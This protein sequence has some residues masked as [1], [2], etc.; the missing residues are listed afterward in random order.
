MK[1]IKKILKGLLI[2]GIAGYISICGL[3]YFYQE[4]LLFF[5][6]K[7]EQDHQFVFENEFEE[8]DIIT[9][10][11]NSINTLLF[12]RENSKGVIFYLHGNAGSLGSLG[13][14]SE[15]FLPL[16]YDVFIIDYPGY[17]KSSN[18]ITS[19]EELFED[20]QYV[21]DDLKK[22]YSEDKIVVVGY[23][24]GT[25]IAAHLA[26]NNNPSKLVLQAPYYSMI[27]LSQRNYPMIPTFILRYDLATNEYLKECDMPVYL[28]HGVDDQTIPVESSEMLSKEL[29]L[30]LYKLENQGH[31]GIG[32]NK[33]ALKQLHKI[34]N[35][36]RTY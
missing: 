22:R 16:G 20:T 23:S 33:E 24:I 8:R 31:N 32:S 6:E 13:N 4:S 11:G 10:S 3:L 2:L 1:W 9:H 34:L 26:S 19:Q 14:V 25:G 7:L 28:F 18:A 15:Y 36:V 30:P 35:D 29:H 21:Y 27:N 5:P 17:G 12:K